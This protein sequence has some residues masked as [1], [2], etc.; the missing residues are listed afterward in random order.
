MR[1]IDLYEAYVRMPDVETLKQDFSI[2]IGRLLKDKSDVLYRGFRN[3]G[4]NIVL[5]TPNK[6]QR[7]AKQGFMNLHTRIINSGILGDLPKREII[8]GGSEEM[9]YQ[10]GAAHACILRNDAMVGDSNV[11]DIYYAFPDIANKYNHLPS[12]YRHLFDFI[13]RVTECIERNYGVETLLP[14]YIDKPTDLRKIFKSWKGY[15][16]MPYVSTFIYSALEEE[17]IMEILTTLSEKPIVDMFMNNNLTQ[18]SVRGM[19]KPREDIEYWTD[20][21][22][23]MIPMSRLDEFLELLK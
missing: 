21:P 23:L 11:E 13:R 14:H 17:L 19:A 9:V 16:L 4:N 7:K 22:T 1:E 2:S 20:K 12:F 8:M 10:Y 3:L 6:T 18:T 5:M 15:D